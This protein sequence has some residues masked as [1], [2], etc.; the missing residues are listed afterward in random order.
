MTDQANNSPLE[1]DATLVECLVN[2]P[3]AT[4][5]AYF[6]AEILAIDDAGIEVSDHARRS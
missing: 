6:L 4:A 5:E 3:P 2:A 1:P